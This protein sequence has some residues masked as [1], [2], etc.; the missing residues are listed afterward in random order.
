MELQPELVSPN[1]L[2]PNPVIQPVNMLQLVIHCLVLLRIEDFK[3][4]NLNIFTF[5]KCIYC[6]IFK[7][8]KAN[9]KWKVI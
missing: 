7:I 4:L 5:Y 3:S 6:V 1:H 9:R 2:Q 8:L